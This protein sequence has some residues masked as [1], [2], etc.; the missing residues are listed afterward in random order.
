MGTVTLGVSLA[1]PEP[2]GSFLQERRAGFGDTAAYGIPTHVTLVPPTEVAAEAVA[3]HRA[4]PR[5]GRRHRPPLPDAAQRHRHLPPALAR[6]LRPGRPCG[7]DACTWLQKQ[8]RDASGPIARE[9]QFPYHPHVTIAHGIAEEAMDEAYEALKEFEAS[10]TCT[11]F[12]LYEQGP[13]GVWR[14]LRDFPFGREG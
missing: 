8:V 3:G 7:A 2:H 4:P 1:V 9:L 6:G 14:K 10:W 11:G 5:R 12:A 13:D